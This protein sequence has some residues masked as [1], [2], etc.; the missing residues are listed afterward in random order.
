YPLG[1]N[2][3]W[4]SNYDYFLKKIQ[5]YG[6]NYVRVWLCPW[7]LQLEDPR[8]PGKYDLRVANALD[9][10]FAL[11]RRRGLYVQLVLRYH[12]MHNGDWSKS[13][14]N[15]ANGGPCTSPGQF[16]TDPDARD[17]HKA[18]LD[19][20][21]ARW[22]HTPALFAWELWNEAD[23]ARADRDS[24]LVAWHKEMANY[25]NQ[26][27]PYDH[28][29]TTSVA[30]PGR[31]TELFELANIDFVPVH[32]YK[33]DVVRHIYDNYLRFRDLGKPVFIGEFSG[34]HKPADDLADTRGVRIHA[35]LWSAFVTPLAG[36][37]M[38][39]WWDTWVDKNELYG[40][41]A[42]LAK[43]AK[44]VDR[45]SK[46]YEVIRSRIRVG[47]DLWAS[48]QGLVCPSEAFLWVYDAG[49]VLR[50]EHP[51]GPLL[52]DGR[53]VKLRG[54]LGG[55]FRVEIWHTATGEPL[56]QTT[57]RTDD[58]VLAF[59]LPKSDRDLAVKI[60]RQGTVEPTLEW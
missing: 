20:V 38:P 21:V 58:G 5:D 23:L 49:Q 42:A 34:G 40:H 9:E 16:F 48:M 41:W 8:E 52:L 39:W 37:A 33:R 57:A 51:S 10:L 14:Y 22:A 60:T 32:F 55:T 44:G 6:G 45:R 36:S 12:G 18:F 13:P 29:V 2:V 35:G 17:Q 24:D 43:F 50:P 19:Y 26:I 11:C 53:T 4:A 28:L 47:E 27:D 30:S 31:N 1:Q 7:N 3:C 15:T 25:L 54:L 59:P 56:D 46:H